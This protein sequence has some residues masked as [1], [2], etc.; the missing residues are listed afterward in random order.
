MND[1]NEN[2]TEEKKD[3]SFEKENY[4]DSGRK[5]KVKDLFA[6]Q[7]QSVDKDSGICTLTCD[8]RV[9]LSVQALDPD[10]ILFNYAP[11]GY[12]GDGF[13]YAAVPENFPNTPELEVTETKHSV[14][15]ATSSLRMEIS[16]KGLRISIFDT[17]GNLLSDDEK[18]FHWEQN[19]QYGGNIVQYSRMIQPGECFY[20]LGDKSCHSEI[21]GR[22]FELWGS[23]TYAY[24]VDT[25]PLYK[26]IPF[27]SVFTTVSL[28]EFSSIIHTVRFSTSARSA[29]T[30][31][32]S[33]L[34]VA[35]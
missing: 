15:V 23:D 1:E 5:I 35:I 29:K 32:L 11:D 12:L 26:N 9:K 24:G 21:R 30:S 17:E 8:N 34:R 7:V 3:D 13:S 4:M 14:H 2:S 6:G 10:V 31:H 25:D 20:G 18:G 16:N 22:R 19:D 27:L 33:G 28:T